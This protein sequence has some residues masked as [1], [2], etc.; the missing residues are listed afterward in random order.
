MNTEKVIG[1][2]NGIVN[3]LSGK[4]TYIVGTIMV[5]VGLVFYLNPFYREQGAQLILEG[6]AIISLRA[7]IKKVE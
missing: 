6:L 2:I 3:I 4:K 5:I 7:G 1:F